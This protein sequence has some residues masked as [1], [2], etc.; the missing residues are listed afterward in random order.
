MLIRFNMFPLIL[1]SVILFISGCKTMT[2]GTKEQPTPLEE[3]ML[4]E[5]H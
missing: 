2:F 1:L 4:V 3:E 5:H